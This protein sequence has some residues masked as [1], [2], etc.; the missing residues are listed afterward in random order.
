MA[1]IV[2]PYKRGNYWTN[3]IDSVTG[4]SVNFEEVT[5]WWDG[6]PM[7]DS[8]ADGEV[9]RKLPSSVGGGYVRRVYDNFGQLFLEKD[10]MAEM[11]ALS[12]TEILLIQIGRYKGVKLNGYYAKGDTPAPIEYL[13]S[14]TL[15]SDDGGSVIEV[16]GIKLAHEFVGEVDIRYFG[17]KGDGV[18]NNTDSIRKAYKAAKGKD[19]IWSEGVYYLDYIQ[20]S[21]SIEGDNFIEGKR[22]C[23]IGRGEVVLKPRNY[24]G[25]TPPASLGIDYGYTASTFSLNG[26]DEVVIENIKC[27]GCMFDDFANDW[28]PVTQSSGTIN[29]Y[30]TRTRFINVNFSKNISIK[31]ITSS[32]MFSCIRMRGCENITVSDCIHTYSYESFLFEEC[33]NLNARNLKSYHARFTTSPVTSDSYIRQ[34][35]VFDEATGTM[36]YEMFPGSADDNIGLKRAAGYGFLLNGCIDVTL[37]DSYSYMAGSECFRVQNG[38]TGVVSN[39]VKV[40]NCTSEDT[41]RYAFS[42]R[43]SGMKGVVFESCI[44]IN[45]GNVDSWSGTPP[46]T[47]E[48]SFDLALYSNPDTTYIARIPSS[49]CASYYLTDATIKNCFSYSKDT[50]H[51]NEN[52]PTE[53]DKR[54]LRYFGANNRGFCITN[55][56]LVSN[57]NTYSFIDGCI[58]KG[59]TLTNLVNVL[60]STGEVLLKNTTIETYQDPSNVSNDKSQRLL[61]TNNHQGKI[62]SIG[63]TFIGGRDSIYLQNTSSANFE[64]KND[65]CINP[66]RAALTSSNPTSINAK[67]YNLNVKGAARLAHFLGRAENILFDNPTYDLTTSESPFSFGSDFD[68][69][70]NCYVKEGSEYVMFVNA[71]TNV[72]SFVDNRWRVAD[73]II[74]S[75]V[76]TYGVTNFGAGSFEL[77]KKSVYRPELPTG[78]VDFTKIYNDSGVERTLRISASGAG[79][80]MT[81]IIFTI[82]D[83]DIPSFYKVYYTT[84]KLGNLF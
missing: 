84:L 49:T 69:I 31:N 57:S 28:Q 39:N 22:F 68:R 5:T 26:F 72:S 79:T 78:T 37:R 34:G 42:T 20:L 65:T 36:L 9:Y 6:T 19:V 8:K 52:G 18:Y 53:Y 40:I 74:F 81:Q 1:E 60:G 15:G 59:P 62:T 21:G 55:H 2:K 50:I 3:L 83:T 76:I 63:N 66:R 67:I 46:E 58:F 4:E 14:E 56:A 77:L 32:K 43:S 71:G 75:K 45:A 48:D 27:E 24:I 25:E 17:A 51:Y 12:P 10:T 73:N 41:R 61:Y 44:V 35:Q 80:G 33:T 82:T 16:G 70:H 7:D 11:R 47:V 23:A 38:V 64:S 54:P 13:L 29:A 30:H